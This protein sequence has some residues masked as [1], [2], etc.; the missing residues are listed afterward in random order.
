MGK[1]YGQDCWRGCKG[2]QGACNWCGSGVCCRYGWRR[3]GNGCSKKDGIRGRG[4]V[5]V[6]KA[7]KKKA[8]K[9]KAAKAATSK[10]VKHYGQD[11]WRG[12]K[13]KQGACNWCGSGV[14]CRY[15]WRWSGNGCSKKD[16]IRG[17]GHV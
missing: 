7:K 14:C 9:K 16:G 4:H 6:P 5:C 12:C 15:G 13:G 2:K 11:C 8:K 17:R 1:H 3:S 10:G